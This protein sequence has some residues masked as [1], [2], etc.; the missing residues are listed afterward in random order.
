MR[1]Y[2]DRM[3]EAS[4]SQGDGLLAWRVASA[5][6]ALAE[7]LA[8]GVGLVFLLGWGGEHRRWS[9]A[10]A[11]VLLALGISQLLL[12]WE[13]RR[14]APTYRPEDIY[15]LTPLDR[16]QRILVRLNLLV[17]VAFVPLLSISAVGALDMEFFPT[18][19]VF[20]A[21]GLSGLRPLLR[22]WKH[23]SWLAVS[24]LPQ[25]PAPERLPR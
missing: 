10:A 6:L 19:F 13:A 4:S 25:R 20:L 11:T 2:V 22:V 9:Y 23:N 15:A 14:R 18:V 17:L 7:L 12:V 24:G 1:L 16:G 3:G 5:V 8:T 21:V